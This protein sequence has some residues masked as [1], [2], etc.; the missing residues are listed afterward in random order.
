MSD[1]GKGGIETLG[2]LEINMHGYL[3]TRVN[4]PLLKFPQLSSLYFSS[5]FF[6]RRD[7]NSMYS[8]KNYARSIPNHSEIRLTGVAIRMDSFTKG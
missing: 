7:R 5:M 6:A 8:Q 3:M 4:D 2:L 1:Q